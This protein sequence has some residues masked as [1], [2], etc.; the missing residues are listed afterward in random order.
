M[1]MKEKNIEDIIQYVNSQ[2]SLG[3]HM[4]D[5]EIN[6]FKVNERVITKRLNRKGYKKIDNQ[7]VLTNVIKKDNKNIKSKFI[8]KYNENIDIQKINELI[9][10]LKPLKKLIQE[11]NKNINNKEIKIKNITNVK[12]KL[13]KID[14]NVLISWEEFVKNHKQYKVQNLISLALEE[15]INKYK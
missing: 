2:L 7:F 10:L 9:E 5:I 12:Q 11:H 1:D 14:T 8:E 13:F 4:K 3:R 6:D 15:F